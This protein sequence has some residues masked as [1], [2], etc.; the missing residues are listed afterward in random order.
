MRS[1]SLVLARMLVIG[2]AVYASQATA[3][4]KIEKCGPI[5]SPGSYVLTKNLKAFGDC[6]KVE[7]DFVTIDLN[8][9]LIEAISARGSS[10]GLGIFDVR[11]TGIDVPRDGVTVRNGTIKGFLGG[12]SLFGQFARIEGVRVLD[13]RQEG[14]SVRGFSI[15]RD[16]IVARSGSAGISASAGGV[17]VG[18]VAT[19]NGHAGI[20]VSLA[21]T[22]VNNTSTENEVDGISGLCPGVVL[23][24]TAVGNATD[25]A[26]VGDDCTTV[27]NSPPP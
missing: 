15:V 3:Q 19:G 24:N 2:L 22:V 11:F 9:F 14:I 27:H 20:A 6:L 4:G 21:S 13:S 7:A 17:V 16:N 1:K 5:T 18:N 23:G 10:P 25:I 26:L 12:I 8:G